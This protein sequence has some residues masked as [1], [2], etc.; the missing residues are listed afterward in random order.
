MI[1]LSGPLLPFCVLIGKRVAEAEPSRH[2]SLVLLCPLPG[3][4]GDL[5]PLRSGQPLLRSGLCEGRAP[6][7]AACGRATVPTEPPGP[8]HP[9][10]PATALP[11]V[12]SE[13]DASRFPAYPPTAPLPPE[14]QG[15]AGRVPSRQDP[16]GVRCRFCGRL[17]S[18]LLRRDF[19]HRT[20]RRGSVWFTWPS[21][22]ASRRS[23]GRLT[24][25]R[26]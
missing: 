19:L 11:P 6:R 16:I 10:R 7:L 15:P 22:A 25:R 12:P 18:G 2:R 4:G 9:C 17:C 1:D 5:S 21:P 8:F 24:P 13:S 26:S 14:S 23:G 20:P 3:P